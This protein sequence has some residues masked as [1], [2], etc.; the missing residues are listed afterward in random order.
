MIRKA[1]FSFLLIFAT[2][3][4][5]L[6]HSSFGH[7]RGVVRDPQERVVKGARVTLRA[8]QSALLLS[9]E[10]GEAGEFSI[11]GIPI[12]EYV[13]SVEA[14]G[15]GK[16]EEAITVTSADSPILQVQLQVAT[17]SEKVT[18]V[19]SP[20]VIASDSPTPTTLV[21]RVEIARAPGADRSN[22]LAAITD[23]VPGAYM[24]HDQLHIRGG[25]QV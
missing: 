22:S 19:E 10:T 1:L 5:G 3:L 16:I 13:L 14:T 25:H 20:G 15:F 7:I 11:Q 8:R 17:I 2:G 9:A 23:Y 18:I 12:G 24:T 6:S 21:N 4:P